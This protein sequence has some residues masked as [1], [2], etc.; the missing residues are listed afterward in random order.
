MRETRPSGSE[1]G[2]VAYPTLPTPIMRAPARRMTSWEKRELG[3]SQK[4]F[5]EILVYSLEGQ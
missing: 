1:G 5:Q 3:K 2:G 4:V